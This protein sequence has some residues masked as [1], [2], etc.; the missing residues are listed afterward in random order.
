[1]AISASVNSE[2]WSTSELAFE[3]MS[4]ATVFAVAPASGPVSGGTVVHVMGSSLVGENVLCRFGLEV[5]AGEYIGGNELCT[6]EINSAVLPSNATGLSTMTQRS[7]QC[8][9][10]VEVACMS[11][12]H[13]AGIVTVEVSATDGG[14][15]TSK[16]EFEFQPSATVLSLQPASGP[17]AGVGVVKVVGEHLVSA[18]PLCGFGLADPSY[19][20]VV[21]SVLAKCEAPAHEAGMVSVEMSISGAG[22]QFTQSGMMYSYTEEA[23]VVAISPRE[24]AQSGGTVVRLALSSVD[25][26]VS[27]CRFGTIGPLSSRAA[28]GGAECASPA[29]EG[30]M[31]A[32]SAS[33]NSEV[34]STSELAFEY[35]SSATV[36]AVAPASGPVSGGTVVHVMGSSLVGENVLCR[37]GLEVV[38]GE[39]IGGNELCTSEIN[40]AVLPSNATGLSTMTQR[41][42]Q[43]MGWVEVACMS[44]PHAAG[45]VTVEVSA[46]DGGFSTSKV[47]FEFQPSATVLS[48]QPASGPSAGVG[49]V[50][51][52]GEHLVS[53][54]PLCGFGLADPSYAEVV[55][56]VLAK[57]EAPAHEAGMVSVEM[58]I[59]GAG[60]QFTQSG[61]MYSYTEEAAVVAISPREGAQSGG[62][63]VRLALSSVDADVSG[64]RFGTIGPL[65]SRAA[66]GGAEC[67]SPAHEGGMVAI[68]ASV[69][70]EVWSTSELAFEYMS[71]A[72][73]F[74]VAP[75]SGPVSG[76]TVVH[77]MGSSLVGEN[78]LCRFGLE[79][80]AGEYIGGNELCTSEINSAVLP[81]NATGLSTMTQRSEQCMGWVEVACM[82]PPHAAGIVTVEVSATDGGFSTSK[83]EFEFQ[84]SA[85]V[86]S[87]QPAS[88]PSAGVGVVKVVGEHLVSAEPL[89]GF[90]LA[91]PSYAEVVSSVLAKCEAPAHALDYLVVA[92]SCVLLARI[93]LML[94]GHVDLAVYPQYPVHL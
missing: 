36:F 64:C 21:S 15:S 61:M 84:P 10:W 62:T 41:S 18:E 57:C 82:S 87:L 67:A 16:V 40:S 55:S 75:A 39:Y 68:S 93:F 4:S 24:G 89:C 2:V 37:F 63:V 12:P 90:G 38:A 43:C 32:I 66:G 50:K 86:L 91:D 7:E 59:S 11:P 1:M 73:V 54:E 14:F 47:E 44:P 80:V 25:A 3:Y 74:A 71:S 20:E 28:G 51:V 65:S 69:N 23:A 35:M 52:V 33:V 45:I 56:S 46:T 60:Q 9:G 58:S 8:M 26:D 53:A 5:V 30:G 78:V 88:G 70:S 72:T 13:A 22:Q 17:S 6:S 19:A 76:G 85:T 48:L 79:V 34:W 42:E 31:V 81:S 94:V 27:G 77:V 92:L 83:V 49:V 29:H